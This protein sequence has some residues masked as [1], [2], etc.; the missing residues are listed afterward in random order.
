MSHSPFNDDGGTG[1]VDHNGQSMYN[2]FGSI[3]KNYRGPG[4]TGIKMAQDAADAANA[5]NAANLYKPAEIDLG[6]HYAF[7]AS[8]RGLPKS[9]AI[10]ILL[11]VYLGPFIFII[12]IIALWVYLVNASDARMIAQQ[13]AQAHII[14]A[15]PIATPSPQQ[16]KQ[17]N[18]SF[19]FHVKVNCPRTALVLTDSTIYLSPNG[20]STALGSVRKG[21]EIHT[22]GE[23]R[24]IKDGGHA[25]KYISVYVIQGGNYVQGV[26][27]AESVQ[28]QPL[29]AQ[30]ASDVSAFYVGEVIEAKENGAD[31]SYSEQDTQTRFHPPVMLKGHLQ[32]GSFVRINEILNTRDIYAEVGDL[33]FVRLRSWDFKPAPPNVPTSQIPSTIR[34]STL[35]P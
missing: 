30:E 21:D 14:A 35:D 19:V 22:D 17:L 25:F 11:L 4:Y 13:N 10:G 26:V 27:S 32:K 18:D 12:G 33:G 31:Y 29:S 24:I 16:Q 1:Q 5:T 3:N 2:C 23:V 8:L 6:S 34:P 15:P 20:P 28:L 7:G 9:K